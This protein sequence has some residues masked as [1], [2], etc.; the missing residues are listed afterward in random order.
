[1][2]MVSGLLEFTPVLALDGSSLDKLSK[3][4]ALATTL[5]RPS[6]LVTMVG[7]SL[8][9]AIRKEILDPST[10]TSTVMFLRN[11]FSAEI[12]SK[13]EVEVT[14][15]VGRCPCLLAPMLS[16]SAPQ[17]HLA[18]TLE[19]MSGLATGGC[20]EERTLKTGIDLDI[21]SVSMVMARP[22]RSVPL[23]APMSR[24]ISTMDQTGEDVVNR[25]REMNLPTSV[26]LSAFLNLA[27]SL[28]LEPP[29]I[30]ESDRVPLLV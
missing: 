19:S 13:A 8:S 21:L 5:E 3:G 14:R 4:P 28:Q 11:G 20:S 12:R 10:Y 23:T 6:S 18:D 22:L 26:H 7:P 2:A 30:R 24:Y 29:T 25:S 15:P 1:M 27:I 17:D 9:V 16:R